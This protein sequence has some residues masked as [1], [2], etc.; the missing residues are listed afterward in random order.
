MGPPGA[1]NGFQL[2]LYH[3]AV[4]TDRIL[5]RS[6]GPV[7][8]LLDGS[9]AGARGGTPA[10]A[11]DLQAGLFRD[12]RGF[13]LSGTWKS[14]TE[15]RGETPESDLTF[16]DLATFD[17]R[18]FE[19][20]TGTPDLVRRWPFLKGARLTLAVDN[21]FDARLE[22]RD[23]AGGQPSGYHPAVLDPVGR[24]LEVSFRKVF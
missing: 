22:V 10:H 13:R 14:G 19:T 15:V 16:S 4:L 18:V 24:V 7:F 17:I 3:T 23:A 1:R 9:A 21:V 11:L 20:F 6:G 12:G 2:S 8:D 5:V